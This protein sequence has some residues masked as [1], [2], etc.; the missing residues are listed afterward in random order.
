M[1]SASES[2]PF[3]G[4]LAYVCRYVFHTVCLVILG[5]VGDQLAEMC[6]LVSTC[7]AVQGAMH[8]L[9]FRRGCFSGGYNSKW[10]AK[11]FVV[12]AIRNL[13]VPSQKVQDEHVE[14]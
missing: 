13:L 14:Q 4:P 5:R 2:I 7:L 11:K 9:Q 10:F 6:N 1:F 12:T 3:E 8:C